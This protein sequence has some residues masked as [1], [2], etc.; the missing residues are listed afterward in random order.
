MK[1]NIIDIAYKIIND[2]SLKEKFM[3][4][5]GKGIDPVYLDTIFTRADYK[6]LAQLIFLMNLSK[7]ENLIN[8]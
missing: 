8:S 6:E 7:L 4:T 1:Y 5:Y 2:E 3:N